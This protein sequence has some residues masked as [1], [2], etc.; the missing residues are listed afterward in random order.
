[1][2]ECVN[3]SVVLQDSVVLFL[4]NLLLRTRLCVSTATVYMH[5]FYVVH[6]V[7]VFEPN[8]MA[9]ACVFLACKVEEE[10]RSVNHFIYAVLRC[11]HRSL[12]REFEVNGFF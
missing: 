4:L 1:M 9:C 11:L 5:R 8:E 10:P 3:Q 2:I 7:S 12:D 6:P